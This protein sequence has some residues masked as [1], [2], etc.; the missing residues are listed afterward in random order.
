MSTKRILLAVFAGL[1]F[2][3]VVQA[4]VIPYGDDVVA[5]VKD[6]FV[7]E[8][9]LDANGNIAVH[10][11][12]V[13]SVKLDATGN[14]VNLGAAGNTVK[15]DPAANTVK[16]QSSSAAPVVTRESSGRVAW[17]WDSQFVMDGTIDNG[18]AAPQ[19]VTAPDDKYIVIEFFSAGAAG[20][21]PAQPRVSLY[22]TKMSGGT[23][24][25]FTYLPT[26][27]ALQE[28]YPL[29]PRYPVFRYFQLNTPVRFY[30]EPGQ[31]CTLV[32]FLLGHDNVASMHIGIDM[33]GYLADGIY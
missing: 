8:Q 30:V 31:T 14:T 7:R 24:S 11:Q 29:D 25:W 21:D 28:P 9:N 16:V 22:I 2:A 3:L 13:A 6:Q 33:S 18:Y 23:W 1:L 32:P 15:L 26:T 12:G 20:N 19:S 4:V 10:E 27:S 17:A 5:A